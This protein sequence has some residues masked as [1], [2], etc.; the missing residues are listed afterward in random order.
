M[1][2]EIPKI[3]RSPKNAHFLKV[4]CPDILLF[5]ISISPEIFQSIGINI[6]LSKYRTKKNGPF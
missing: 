4:K 3:V 1:K 2:I 5:G 6:E